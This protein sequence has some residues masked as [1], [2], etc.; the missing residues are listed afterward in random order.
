MTSRGR[1]ALNTK[2][3]S[4]HWGCIQNK[5]DIV[6]KKISVAVVQQGESRLIS[7]T[8]RVVR[9]QIVYFTVLAVTLDHWLDVVICMIC[10]YLLACCSKNRQ[11]MLKITGKSWVFATATHLPRLIRGSFVI[12]FTSNLIQRTYMPP[13]EVLNSYPRF[14]HFRCKTAVTPAAE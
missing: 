9:H 14:P 1:H 6:L 7:V 13:V 12:T 2:R 8:R 5:P 11:A 10:I 3:N 4:A